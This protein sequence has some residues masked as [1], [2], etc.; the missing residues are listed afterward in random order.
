MK[1][2]A[3]IWIIIIAALVGGYFVWEANRAEVP[4]A[5]SESEEL[6]TAVVEGSVA[7]VFNSARAVVVEDAAGEMWSIAIGDETALKDSAGALIV[8]DDFSLLLSPGTNVRAVV[9]L[10]D[11]RVG[12]AREIRVVSGT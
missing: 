1:R 3:V 4:S 11:A 12:R 9:D 7:E 2:K 8:N 5:G 6:G 10:E